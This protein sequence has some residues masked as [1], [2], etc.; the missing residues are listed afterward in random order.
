MVRNARPTIALRHFYL[1]QPR[2]VLYLS[3]GDSL[4]AFGG[5]KSGERTRRGRLVK[6]LGNR[7]PAVVQCRECRRAPSPLNPPDTPI[8]RHPRTQHAW[9]NPSRRAHT[10]IRTRPE[11]PSPIRS[12]AKRW[13]VGAA[14]GPGWLIPTLS[15][16]HQPQ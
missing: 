13:R 9:E 12:A 1:V 10:P 14:P 3:P 2:F 7:P 8:P 16:T 5:V 11:M 15:E 4:S 6:S